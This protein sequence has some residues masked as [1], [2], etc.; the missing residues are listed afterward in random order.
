M[1]LS[2]KQEIAFELLKSMIM[3]RGSHIESA[4][5]ANIFANQILGDLR[6]PRAKDDSSLMLPVI[7]EK[8]VTRTEKFSNGVPNE[9]ET[10]EKLKQFYVENKCYYY[11]IANDT[12]I[13]PIELYIMVLGFYK[14]YIA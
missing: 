7:N 6:M 14:E 11:F 2:T 13:L 9:L 8:G 12:K 4:M 1:E 3:N 5:Q 10:G